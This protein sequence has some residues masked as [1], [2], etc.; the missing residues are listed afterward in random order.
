[1]MKFLKRRHL[2]QITV[3]RRTLESS[4]ILTFKV[5]Q[6]LVKTFSHKLTLNTGGKYFIYM[7]ER[8]Q[9]GADDITISNALYYCKD[10]A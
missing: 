8:G 4:K 7:P 3:H 6:I 1:M 9:R 2:I 10:D 5:T